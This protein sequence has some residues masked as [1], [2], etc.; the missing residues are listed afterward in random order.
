MRPRRSSARGSKLCAPTRHAIDARVA[1]LGETA[2]LDGARVGLEGNLSVGRKGDA[3]PHRARASAQ[4]PAA[5]TDWACRPRRTPYRSGGPR[6]A[7]V[8]RRNPG[9]AHRCS[10]SGGDA[11]FSWCELKSQYGHLRTHQGMCTYSASGTAGST[12]RHAGG[13]APAPLMRARRAARAAR[14]APGRGGCSRFFSSGSSSAAVISSSGS[15]KYG[16]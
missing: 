10:R 4:I 14:A 15:Q 3:L 13:A 12:R 7:A 16:S 5:G 2:A 1:I 8:R 11:D 6:A 9:S